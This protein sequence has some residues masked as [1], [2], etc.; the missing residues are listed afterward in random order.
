MS[1]ASLERTV[2][3]ER[4]SN[5]DSPA[6]RTEDAASEYRRLMERLE[7][8]ED[9]LALRQ[10][11]RRAGRLTTHEALTARLRRKGRL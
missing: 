1:S 7:L 3:G 6:R 5:L 4:P 8:M 10:A 2:E 9:S 11:K